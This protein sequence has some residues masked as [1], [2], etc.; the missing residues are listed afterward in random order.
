M[1]GRTEVLRAGRNRSR[2]LGCS[3]TSVGCGDTGRGI[4]AEELPHIFERF[5]RVEKARGDALEGTGLGLA[6]VQRILQLHDSPIE[7]D[8]EPGVGTSFR[9]ALPS[10]A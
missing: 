9:F 10:A 5:Y 8:S 3:Q 2:Q 7:V 1:V 6:I 4:P